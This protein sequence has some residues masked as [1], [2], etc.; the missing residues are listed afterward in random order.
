MM[1]RVAV[2]I[3]GFMIDSQELTINIPTGTTAPASSEPVAACSSS[4][5]TGLFPQPLIFELAAVV[6]VEPD[7]PPDE[8]EIKG[9]PSSTGLTGEYPFPVPFPFLAIA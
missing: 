2:V 6:G 8:P 3:G 9:D 5:P 7:S 1:I 4:T